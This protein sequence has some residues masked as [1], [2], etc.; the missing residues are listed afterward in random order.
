MA[1]VQH[2]RRAGQLSPTAQQHSSPAVQELLEEVWRRCGAPSDVVVEDEDVLSLHWVL[3]LHAFVND[4]AALA[5]RL[6]RMR[7]PVGQYTNFFFHVDGLVG[8]AVS[9]TRKT[10][11]L[12]DQLMPSHKRHI[13]FGDDSAC[14]ERLDFSQFVALVATPSSRLRWWG[15]KNA[16]PAV[17]PAIQTAFDLIPLFESASLAP[18]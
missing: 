12:V 6:H 16:G 11:H 10:R 13:F 4:D 3:F 14:T 15:G 1:T 18:S 7:M 2:D 17:G 9:D 5:S 8:L